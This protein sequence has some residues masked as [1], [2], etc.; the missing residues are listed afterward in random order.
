L[1]TIG[2]KIVE[3]GHAEQRRIFGETD[4]IVAKKTAAIVRNMMI[5]L[6]C[7]GEP[8]STSP[9]LAALFCID[10]I[11]KAVS[12]IKSSD[13]IVVAYEPIWAIGKEKPAEAAYVVEVVKGIKA[14]LDSRSGASRIIYGGSAGPGLLS[15]LYP[16]VDG[17]FLGRF[18]HAVS[19]VTAVVSEVP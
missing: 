15:K 4:E 7:V 12:G 9:E 11:K 14:Y 17:L 10:Q 2:V 3:V 8:V 1:A 16:T 5:P 13:E 19:N 6:I 18:G